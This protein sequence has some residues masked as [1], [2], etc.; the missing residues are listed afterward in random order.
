MNWEATGSYY[1]F[2]DPYSWGNGTFNGQ[3]LPPK[4]YVFPTKPE[5]YPVI[6]EGDRGLIIIRQVSMGWRQAAIDDILRQVNEREQQIGCRFVI[7]VENLKDGSLLVEWK[8][9]SCVE[10]EAVK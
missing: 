8:R 5:E 4:P 6:Q 3:P 10:T 9:N 2:R 1:Q 7:L